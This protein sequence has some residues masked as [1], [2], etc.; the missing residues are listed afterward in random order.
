MKLL[1]EGGSGSA[2]S[3]V[4]DGSAD[5]AVSGRPITGPERAAFPEKRFYEMIFGIQALTFIVPK[6]VWES[7]VHALNRDQIRRIYER[8]I[9]NWKDVGGEDRPI[10]FYN[11][12]QGH[13]VWEFFVTWLYGEQRKAPLGENFETV[14]ESEETRNTVEFNAGSISVAPAGVADNKEVFALSIRDDK[15]EAIEPTPRNIREKRYPVQ[16]PLFLVTGE[17]PTGR[18]KDIV[19]FMLGKEA[20]PLIIRSELTPIAE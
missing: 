14:G 6:D 13:G 18:I 16:R 19:E 8:E 12:E 20:L 1:T 7:G 9:T 3:S 15:G 17:R 11:P 4:G 10:K 2:I 5:I